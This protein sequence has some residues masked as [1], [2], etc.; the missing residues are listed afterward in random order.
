MIFK[1]AVKCTDSELS[2]KIPDWEHK[3][4]VQKVI[5]R[6]PEQALNEQEHKYSKDYQPPI[7]QKSRWGYGQINRLPNETFLIAPF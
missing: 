4:I 7:K 3:A 1:E 6:K 5:S 2:L